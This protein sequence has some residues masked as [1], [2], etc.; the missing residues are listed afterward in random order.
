VG[1][2]GSRVPALGIRTLSGL[3]IDTDKDWKGY[4][5]INLGK[6]SVGDIEMSNE[7]KLTEHPEHGVILLS[8]D[9][10]GFKFK[11]EEV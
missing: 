6:V 10:E 3:Q 9:G 4:N 5:I 11:K 7:W 8:P 2:L 1:R